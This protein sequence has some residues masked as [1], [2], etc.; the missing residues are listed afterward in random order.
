[1]SDLILAL[2]GGGTKTELALADRAGDV[3]FL[4]RG[5]S[6][7]PMDNADWRAELEK[8]SGAAAGLLPDVRFAVLG[9]PGHGE[10]KRLDALA[11]AA[12]A[13]L[14]PGRRRVINDVEMALDGAFLDV[15]GILVLAGTGSMA[16]ARD[17]SGAVVRVGGWGDA[18]GD[19]GSAYWIGREALARTSQAL[20]GR[21]DASGFAAGIL[22]DLG[23]DAGDG[24]NALM[25]WCYALSERRSGIAAVAKSVDRLA[26]SG[27]A[28][29]LAILR[30]ATEQLSRHVTAIRHLADMELSPWSHAGQVFSSRTIRDT[31]A[32]RHGEPSLPS[33][34]PVGGGLWRAA[35]EAGWQTGETWVSRLAESLN[36]QRQAALATREMG[37]RHP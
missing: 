19:E 2:D 33:L 16:M 4:A 32:A 30:E 7:N 14:F 28:T 36:R 15:A 6:T 27:D 26:E 12:A 21:G 1:V 29:A 10:V 35:R 24:H 9:L 23:L 3:V 22:A 20:D 37:G 18:F 17:R 25:G 8:L 31:L 11:A 34:P 5:R 13:D